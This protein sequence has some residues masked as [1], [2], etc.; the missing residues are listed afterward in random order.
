MGG[1]AP[2]LGPVSEYPWSISRT[3]DRIALGGGMLRLLVLKDVSL[4]GPGAGSSDN[5]GHIPVWGAVRSLFPCGGKRALRCVLLT[6]SGHGH[7]RVLGVNLC[8]GVHCTW[9]PDGDCLG[10]LSL[11][12]HTGDGK[13]DG[14]TFLAR[15]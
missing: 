9:I 5:V 6:V 11:G 13:S 3:H 10:N 8:T 15:T 14:E 1:L 4:V 2:G 12:R 7:F